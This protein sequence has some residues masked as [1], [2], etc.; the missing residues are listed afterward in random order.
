MDYTNLY[1]FISSSGTIVPDDSSILMGIQTKFKE[2]FGSDI[3]LSSETPVGRL[4]EAFSVVIKSALG[5]TAQTA[6]QFN[7]NEA[8]GLYLDSVAQIYGLQR[9]VATKTKVTIK[10]FF[11]DLVGGTDTIPAGALI[12]SPSTGKLFSVDAPIRNDGRRDDTTGRIYAMGTA[13]ATEAGRIVAPVGSVTAIQTSVLG[14][15]G[16]TN[17][18]PTYVGTD[19]ETDAE[20]RRRI[21]ASRPIGTGFGT[22]LLSALNRMGSV[23]SSCILENNTGTGIMKKDI[24]IPPH[25]IYVAVDFVDTED[26]RAEIADAISRAKPVGTGMVTDGV[27]GLTPITQTVNYGYNGNYSQE[28]T[29]FKPKRTGLKIEISYRYGDY[30][31]AGITNDITDTVTEFVSEIGIGETVYGADI[32]TRL[33]NNLRI[34]VVNVIMQKNGDDTPADSQIEMAGYEMPYVEPGSLVLIAL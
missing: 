24:V 34:G 31:G 29:F 16:V 17:V 33:I 15:E 2:I 9:T 28:I 32:A 3:D 30:R 7:V 5:V 8:T 11:K 1:N 27:K 6:N 4:I 18:S 19:L 25:S 13:T 14:W 26:T 22:H 21:I 20:F 12:L 23:N 10:C